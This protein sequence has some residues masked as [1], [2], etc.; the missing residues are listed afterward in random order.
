MYRYPL[1]P[2]LKMVKLP[3][4]LPSNEKSPCSFTFFSN[5]TRQDKISSGSGNNKAILTNRTPA[6]KAACSQN[7]GKKFKF[8]YFVKILHY[9]G[10][11]KE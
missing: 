9:I 8:S 3:T 1:P 5:Q 7:G 4:C 11:T 10:F 2:Q 6:C